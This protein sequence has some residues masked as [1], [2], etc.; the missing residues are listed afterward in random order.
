MLLDKYDPKIIQTVQNYCL[1]DDIFF[2]CFMENNIPCM[3][4]ILRIIMDIGDLI[5]K[6]VETQHSVSSLVA[7]NVRFD[8]FATDGQGK[9]Y[10]IEV[11]NADSGAMP[12]RAR[13][14]SSMM[15]YQSLAKGDDWSVLPETYV[16]FIT[17]ND[18]L[19][20]G[21]PIYHISRFIEETGEP[22]ED[23]T[24]IIYVNASC[25]DDTPLGNLM[26]DFKA[27]S[28]DKLQSEILA[29]RMNKLKSSETEVSK[30]CES[31]E[32]Y[33]A[34]RVLKETTKMLAGLVKDGLLSITEAAKRAGMTEAAF[35]K[36]AML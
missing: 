2:N 8:V 5:V 6:S 22:F 10:D 34:E 4:Y 23:K 31:V 21:R 20:R 36:A 30:M 26:R 25:E 3:E 7:R 28:A 14:N 9:E 27:N 11:Q 32:K 29:D 33:A 1:L 19:K 15:D 35:R 13:Y 16:V 17:K 24:H 12:E 18:V